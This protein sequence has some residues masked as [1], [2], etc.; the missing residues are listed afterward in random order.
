MTEPR[1]VPYPSETRSKGWRF[2][3]DLEK[4]H[5]SDTWDLAAEIPMAQHALLMM[6]SISWTQ[7]PCGSMPADP[8]LIRAKLKIPRD[9]W[10]SMRDIV[11]RG[12][13]LADD[14][15]LYHDVIVT[16]VEAM[17][18]KREKDRLR[19]RNSRA[20]RSASQQSRADVTRDADVTPPEVTGEFDTRTRTSTSNTPPPPTRAGE[21]V[22]DEPNPPTTAGQFQSRNAP[23]SCE[24][25][26]IEEGWRPSPAF[27]AQAKLMGVAVRDAALMQSGLSEFIAFWIAKPNECRTQTEWDHALAKSLKYAQARAAASP[28]AP[29]NP[30]RQSSPV[31]TPNHGAYDV[32][33][34]A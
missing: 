17:L 29:A 30:R 18:E 24:V 25:F 33:E 11:L 22:A 32:V 19:T 31:N 20:N 21:D 27:E 4:I 9:L 28:K 14:G 3:L 5:N 7:E 13:W 1:P 16:R 34:R 8:D 26:P 2:E 12:W 23:G 6:W 10:D 15:R